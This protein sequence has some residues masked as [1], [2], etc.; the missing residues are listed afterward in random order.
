MIKYFKINIVR[1]LQDVFD[2]PLVIQLTDDEKYLWKDLQVDEC[3]N[4]AFENARDIIAVGFDLNKTLI[5]SDMD[6]ID[7]EFYRLFFVIFFLDISFWY[8]CRYQKKEK[9]VNGSSSQETLVLN[10][11]YKYVSIYYMNKN[12]KNIDKNWN[13][14]LIIIIID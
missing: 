7:S 11:S 13:F 12:F 1:W 3:N 10:S 6:I 5:F 4:L 2:I 9:K 14:F 8:V